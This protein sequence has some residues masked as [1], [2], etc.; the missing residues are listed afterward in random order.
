MSDIGRIFD[1][2]ILGHTDREHPIET[3]I[4]DFIHEV[5]E[6]HG[7]DPTITSGGYDGEHGGTADRKLADARAQRDAALALVD[8]AWHLHTYGERSPG[9]V[10]TWA[11]W[12]RKARGL[13]RD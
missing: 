2:L 13:K 12:E 3:E 7:F 4:A 9:G 5:C 8:E 11:E 1:I 10:E 6:R